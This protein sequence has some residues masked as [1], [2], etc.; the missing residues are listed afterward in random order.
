MSLPPPSSIVEILKPV[1]AP[2]RIILKNTAYAGGVE[3]R[4]PRVGNNHFYEI[5][6]IVTSGAADPGTLT[7][8]PTS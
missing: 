7:P 8:S 4:R 3:A 6:A 5:Q 2:A 1:P